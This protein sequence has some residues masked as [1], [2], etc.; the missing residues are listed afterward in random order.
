MAKAPEHGKS[1]KGKVTIF[2]VA[3]QARVSIK[4][5]AETAA[6]LLMD[7]L[8]GKAAQAPEAPFPCEIAVRE[9]AA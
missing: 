3:A 9:S 5:M 6:R 8:N 2:E 4:E 1:P 7:R